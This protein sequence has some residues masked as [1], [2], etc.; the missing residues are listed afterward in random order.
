MSTRYTAARTSLRTA[1]IL[2]IFTL[3]FTALMA[4]TY[5]ATRPAIEASAIEEKMRLINEVLPATSYDNVLLDDFVVLGPTP[6]LGI[7]ESGRV[8]RARQ[9]NTPSALILEVVA[10]DGYAGRI[11]LIVAVGADGKITGV[12]AT[13]HRETPGLG[14][15]IDPRKDRNKERP[16]IGQFTGISF[17][18]VAPERWQVKRD[19]GTFDFRVGATITARAVTRASGRALRFAVEHHD[20]LFAAP[21]GDRI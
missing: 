18:N 3:A 5:S 15:Y 13:G 6:E 2:T 11:Q 10:P 8:Y 7:T 16:W 4:V 17:E 1:G 21:A 19:G 12:R 20:S 9:G 14:D